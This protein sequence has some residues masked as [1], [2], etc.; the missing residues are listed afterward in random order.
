ME[1]EK[2]CKPHGMPESFCPMC[3]HAKP[4]PDWLM[5]IFVVVLGFVAAR[6]LFS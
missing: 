6:I 3:E 1:E 2:R 4:P 5:L